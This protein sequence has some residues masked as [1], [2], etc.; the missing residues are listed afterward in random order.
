MMPIQSPTGQF[1]AFICGERT[2]LLL[3]HRQFDS[4][5]VVSF[6]FIYP[7]SRFSILYS[8]ELLCVGCCCCF[9]YFNLC[10]QECWFCKDNKIPVL[11]ALVGGEVASWLVRW[12]P[13][14]PRAVRVRVLAGHCVVFSGNTLKS[15]SASLHRGVGGNPAM[16]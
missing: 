15:H 5:T 8:Y 9:L 7:S 4:G 13:D 1:R 11:V 16:D 10:K 6:S 12:I 3:Y 2:L 14:P